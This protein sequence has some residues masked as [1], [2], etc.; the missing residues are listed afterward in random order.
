MLAALSLSAA[1]PDA[2]ICTVTRT[3]AMQWFRCADDSVWIIEPTRPLRVFFTANDVPTLRGWSAQH[4]DIALWINGSYHNGDYARPEM[5]G[6]LAID[7]TT[8]S[9]FRPDDPQLSRIIAIN[10]QGRIASVDPARTTLDPSAPHH[11][12][13]LQTGPAILIE[14]ELPTAEIAASLNGSDRYKRTAIGRTDMGEAVIVIAK[15]PRSLTDL[16][17]IVRQVNRYRERR[18]SLINLDG[19][20][21]TAIHAPAQPGLSYGADK[22]TPIVIGVMQ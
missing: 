19:G 17:T 1:P 18:L 5:V 11:R 4:P 13:L 8:L 15:T 16:G 2:P 3:D 21:S 6:T 22:V 12:T 20:P 10:D 7:G 9:A 14:G